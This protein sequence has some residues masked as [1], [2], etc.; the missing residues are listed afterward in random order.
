MELRPLGLAESTYISSY[1]ST[2][3]NNLTKNKKELRNY[4]SPKH[5]KTT[6]KQTNKNKTKTQ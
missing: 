5:K 6:N 2:L 4:K 1:T 3:A